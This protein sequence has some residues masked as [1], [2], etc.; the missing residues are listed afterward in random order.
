MENKV[1]SFSDRLSKARKKAPENYPQYAEY[2]KLPP[3]AINIEEAVLGA[4]MLEKDAL[5]QVLD[6]LKPDMF[7]KEEHKEIYR[8]I[9]SLFNKSTPVDILTVTT[10]LRQNEKL[11]FVGGPYYISELTNRVGTSANIEYHSRILVEKFLLREL[12][13]IS[14]DIQEDA[15]EDSTDVFDLLDKA[16]RELFNVSFGT[17][18]SDYV[19]MDSLI[20]NTL[21]NIE[22]LQSDPDKSKQRAVYSGFNELDR[23]TNGWHP[24]DLIIIASRPGVGK[25]SLA[26]TIARNVAIDFEKGVAVFSLEMSSEQLVHR[27]LSFESELPATK[28]RNG[29][30]EDYQWQQLHAKIGKLSNAPIFIDDTPSINI[31][32]LRA[33]CRRLKSHYDI[34]LVVIDYLQL[35]NAH[36]DNRKN[37]NREQEISQISRSLKAMAKELGI[38]VIALSQ[39]SREV[40]KRTTSKRPILSDLRESGSIE[41]DADMVLFIY[42]PEMYGLEDSEKGSLKGLAE[43]IVAKNRHGRV[44]TAQLRFVD[45]YAKFVSEEESSI[46]TNS[47]GTITRSSSLN[48]H[49]EE[50]EMP[51]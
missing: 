15:F 8:S 24:S 43:I 4:L 32:E 25:T 20:S 3:Q 39:L 12:I 48:N 19:R 2:G 1:D 10:E 33:K 44:D 22:K 21:S 46:Q 16:E 38:P 35:M 50:E 9:M 36:V 28:I 45:T 29:E 26:L 6:F 17:L 49:L 23:I 40:E 31:F 47:D 27:L 37:V 7:Y 13:R 51:F 34:G 42:R 18:K 41:Q 11:D 14:N 30:L 5:T